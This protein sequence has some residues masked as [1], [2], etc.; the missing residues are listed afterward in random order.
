MTFILRVWSWL[1]AAC[2]WVARNLL[3][4]I[5]VL[6]LVVFAV[7]AAAVGF[8]EIQVG[9][10][11]A[12]LLGKKKASG[13]GVIEV[14]NSVPEG[15][16]APDGTL[17]QPGEPDSRGQTQAVVVPIQE[18]GILSNPNTVRF[19]PPGQKD[20]V[21]LPLPDGVKNRDVDQVIVVRPQVMVVTVKDASG[22]QAEKV[23]DL[24]RKYGS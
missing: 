9:G 20:P 1:Q 16:I 8:R 6:L 11:I 19:L 18:P 23:E 15:R 13:G 17:I 14:A 10:L 4:P 5:G 7:V 12:R 24:L 22:I 3:G 21:E 2:R